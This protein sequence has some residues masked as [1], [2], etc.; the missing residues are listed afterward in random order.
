MTMP[1]STIRRITRPAFTLLEL[2][3]VVAII[4]I[5]LGLMVPSYGRLIESANY[6]SAVNL[7]TA[8]LGNARA[9]AIRSGQHTAVAFL[10]D[11]ETERTTIMVLEQLNSQGGTLTTAGSGAYASVMR[12]IPGSVP[13][14]M[15]Q[16]TGVYALAFTH[17]GTA[18]ADQMLDATLP[19][20]YAGE[21]ID[22][23]N[24]E[25]LPWIFPRNDARNFTPRLK[26][27]DGSFIDPWKALE[28]STPDISSD[29]ARNAVR[30]AVSFCILFSPDG[31]VVTGAPIR[32]E[33]TLDLYIEYEDDRAGLSNSQ[34]RQ[35]DNNRTYDPQLY[36]DL[37]D[38]PNPEVRMRGAAMLAVVDLKTLKA[39]TGFNQPWFQRPTRS[40]ASISDQTVLSNANVSA[41]SAWI[42]ENAEIIAFN[43]YT[44]HVI[45][46]QQR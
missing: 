45:R 20:W 14:E 18:A 32:G 17:V 43:R 38:T 8:T 7:V 24:T 16:G 15:P 34:L 5:A 37:Q 33:E 23:R 26:N 4:V 13:E 22:H 10:F 30:Q 3:V 12:P 44:G 40:R 31:S 35:V 46:K 29:D 21:R 28:S 41:I 1:G 25:I 9:H 42:D 2:L 11:V 36:R 6:A 27:G 19:H 39:E